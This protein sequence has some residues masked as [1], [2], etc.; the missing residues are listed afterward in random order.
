MPNLNN[1]TIHYYW[2]DHTGDREW[3][4]KFYPNIN[5]DE[6]NFDNE[7]DV[8]EMESELTDIYDTYSVR[9]KTKSYFFNKDAVVNHWDSEEVKA[10]K[11]QMNRWQL[12]EYEGSIYSTLPFSKD[13][14]SLIDGTQ[15]KMKG[16]IA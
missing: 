8:E 3:L 10:E 6:N 15:S 12:N 1:L 4:P 14:I 5:E 13:V 11:E 16:G 2:I 9:L 7:E